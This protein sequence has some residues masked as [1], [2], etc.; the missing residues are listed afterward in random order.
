MCPENGFTSSQT[1]NVTVE[2][3][4]S[5]TESVDFVLLVESIDKFNLRYITRIYK[6][7]NKNNIYRATS[8]V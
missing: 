3:A 2:V 4:T 8:V 5:S 6:N 7:K 1:Q